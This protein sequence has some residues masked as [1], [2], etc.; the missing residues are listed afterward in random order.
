MNRARVSAPVWRVWCLLACCFWGPLAAADSLE[1][2]VD[3]VLGL[4]AREAPEFSA[5]VADAHAVLVFPEVVSMNFGTGGQYGEGVLLVSGEP[6]AHYASSGPEALVLPGNASH[7]T[8]VLLFMTQ[9]AL[10]EFRNRPVWRLGV[11]GQV[12]ALERH[13]AGQWRS[14]S[15]HSAV[16]GFSLAGPGMHEPLRLASNTLSRIR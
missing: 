6:V 11:D 16:L 12:V 15:G 8:D 4:L 10:W 13:S 9:A 1:G 2:R 14:A 5:L 3:E 7:R